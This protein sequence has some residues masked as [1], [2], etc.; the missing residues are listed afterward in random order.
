MTPTDDV[1]SQTVEMKLATVAAMMMMIMTTMTRWR[2]GSYDRFVWQYRDKN[3]YPR[4]CWIFQSV[5]VVVGGGGVAVVDFVVVVVVVV[6]ASTPS[7]SS[8][9]VFFSSYDCVVFERYLY[10]SKYFNTTSVR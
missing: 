1:P 10:T 7:P 4:D 3:Y 5:L 2:F 6:V 8:I 9:F